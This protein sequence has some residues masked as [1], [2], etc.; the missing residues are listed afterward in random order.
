VIGTDA[1]QTVSDREAKIIFSEV[2]GS[3]GRISGEARSVDFRDCIGLGIDDWVW[4]T[5]DVLLN[6]LRSRARSTSSIAGYGD[7]MKVFFRYLTE[8]RPQPFVSSPAAVS[9]IHVAQYTVWLVTY[10]QANGWAIDWPRNRRNQL[11]AVLTKM[12]EL[13]LVRGEPKRYFPVRN[14]QN[15]HGM[16]GS[17]HTSYSDPELARLVGA[18]KADLV[19]CHHGRLTLNPSEVVANRY[20]IVATRSGANVT[21]LLEMSRD[22]L[23]PG[24]L[25]GTMRM[26]TVKHRGRKVLDRMVKGVIAAAESDSDEGDDLIFA[27]AEAAVI[28]RTL[29]DTVDLVNDAPARIRSRVWLYRSTQNY[30]R[31][32]VKCLS[33]ATISKAAENMIRRHKLLGDDGLPL[34]VNSSRLRKSFGK[35]A[36]RIS[37]GDI[38]VVA[39]LLG[40]TPRVADLNYMTIDEQLKTDGARFIGQELTVRLRSDGTQTRAIAI[41]EES[42]TKEGEP[43]KVVNTPVSACQNTLH[44]ALAPNDGSNHCDMFVMCLF[45]PSFA[46]V[47]E[48]DDLWR[49]YSYQIFAKEELGHLNAIETSSDPHKQRLRDLYERAIPFIDEFPPRAFGAKLAGDAK[50]RASHTLHPFWAYQIERARIR[51]GQSELDGDEGTQ[52]DGR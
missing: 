10:G 9:A 28:Q 1:A 39:N 44:G 22:A 41:H 2:L 29:A 4:A 14:L 36:F 20:L 51:R 12:F 25:P 47:G 50:A 35:R 45:C 34:R 6:F 15:R 3:N 46:V 27:L 23:L 21:P 33:L 18:L 49:L 31:G 26:R 38:V 32:E 52:R 8:G 40:N 11:K 7:G 24:L 30:T 48:P 37:D 5:I 43:G 13:G 42:A 16:K 17:R 19:D